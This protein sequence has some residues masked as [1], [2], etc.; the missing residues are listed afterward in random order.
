MTDA[1]GQ[2]T[3]TSLEPG[4]YTIRTSVGF[5]DYVSQTKPVTLEQTVAKTVDFAL[6]PGATVRFWPTCL[7]GAATSRPS[8]ATR[9]AG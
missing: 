2:Y 3:V 9:P 1:A 7:P 5:S 6:D 4:D 8:C